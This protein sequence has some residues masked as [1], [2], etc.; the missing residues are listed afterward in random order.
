MHITSQ[1]VT[2]KATNVGGLHIFLSVIYGSN[3][4][5]ERNEL[6]DDLKIY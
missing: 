4:S 5:Y 1:Q 3:F 2:V 6:W